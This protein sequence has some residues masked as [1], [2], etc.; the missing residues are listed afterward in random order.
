MKDNQ[1]SRGKSQS[2]YKYLPDSWIDF[3]I[4]GKYRK[5]YIAHVNRWNSEQLTDINKKRLLRIVN[6]AVDS[7]KK[8]YTGESTVEPTSGFGAQL[9]IDTCDVLTPKAGGEERGIVAEISPLTFYCKVCH[10][11]YQFRNADDYKKYTKCRKCNIELTQ[12]R[13]IYFCKCGWSSDKHPVYCYNKSHGSKE[14]YWYGGYEFVCKTCGTKIPMM[15]RCDIC[16]TMCGPK[17]A[18][19]PV[20]YIPFSLTLIDLINEKVES[21]ITDTSYGSLIT[22]AYWL[23]KINREEL[24]TIINNGIITDGEEYDKKYNEYYMMFKLQLDEVSAI[25]AAKAAADHACG[26]KY[27]EIVNWVK[28][29]IFVEDID[30]K[31]FAEMLIEYDMVLNSNDI[32]TLDD[33]KKVAKLLN[34]NANP[35]EFDSI[36]DKFGISN[37]QVCGDIPFVACS[38]GYTRVKSQYENGVQ[39]RAFKEEKNGKKNV[40]ATK[41]RTEGVLFEFNRKKILEWLLDNNIITNEE[42]PDMGS[43]LDIKLWFVNN[44]KIDSIKTFTEIDKENYKYTYYVYRLIHSISHLI[45]KSA[46]GLCGLNKD[47]ISEYIFAGVPAV[48]IYCQNSQGFNL[49]ALFNIFEA[50]FDKWLYNAN[51]F[52]KKCVFDPICIERYSA[53]TGCLF[54]N[55]ISC[56]H[57]NKDLDRRLLIGHIEKETLNRCKGFWEEII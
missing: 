5:N 27:N 23:G 10:K 22:I 33:A 28:A 3:S 29:N 55:E 44:I 12:L 11:V 35:D 17:V 38:Y 6:Q 4:R 46:A 1:M 47:S 16:G 15:K 36:A 37:T 41:L 48:M 45:I 54:L 30:L 13:Q 39:L 32:S 56:E 31:K 51:N 25:V 24:V 57:F 52:A 49:G 53:C 21:F 7:F 9:S 14:I 20:Q 26:N 2:L 19:D 40:Y 50:Y 34:T 18:L 43:E 42:L 8:Q